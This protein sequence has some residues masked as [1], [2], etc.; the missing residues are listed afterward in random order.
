[1]NG[2]EFVKFQRDTLDLKSIEF[3][4]VLHRELYG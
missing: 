3:G 2:G 1:M 4:D